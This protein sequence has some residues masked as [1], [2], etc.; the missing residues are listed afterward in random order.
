MAR[1]YI[2]ANGENKKAG[3]LQVGYAGRCNGGESI[4]VIAKGII[5]VTQVSQLHVQLHQA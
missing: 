5:T 2:Q 1:Y 3:M 4:S